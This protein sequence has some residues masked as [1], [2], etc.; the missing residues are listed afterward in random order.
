MEIWLQELIGV[1]LAWFK[2]FH[3]M[4]VTVFMYTLAEGEGI[5]MGDFKVIELLLG[6]LNA[7]VNV[8]MP[9]AMKAAYFRADT[10]FFAALRELFES[11][12]PPGSVTSRSY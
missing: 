4:L 5:A 3:S 9:D 11:V 8:D 12:F 10:K 7:L 2:V 1:M 6:P